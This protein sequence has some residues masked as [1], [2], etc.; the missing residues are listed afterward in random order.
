MSSAK[1][2]IT[3][4]QKAKGL[5]QRLGIAGHPLVQSIQLRNDVRHVVLHCH[6]DMSER[7]Q[8]AADS[9]LVGAAYDA[10]TNTITLA[11]ADELEHA[12]RDFGLHD[13]DFIFPEP[14]IEEVLM[15]SSSRETQHF[16]RG[17]DGHGLNIGFDVR[18]TSGTPQAYIAI[19]GDIEGTLGEMQRALTR[20]T[21]PYEPDPSARR[22]S[23]GL[24]FTGGAGIRIPVPANDQ[25]H[26]VNCIAGVRT[27]DAAQ[28]TRAAEELTDGLAISMDLHRNAKLSA[29]GSS[30]AGAAVSG[31]SMDAAVTGHKL[32]SRIHWR[33]EPNGQ[34]GGIMLVNDRQTSDRTKK[35]D[36]MRQK[37]SAAGIP[38]KPS[39]THAALIL[40]NP[41]DLARALDVLQFDGHT[42]GVVKA[43]YARSQT[44]GAQAGKVGERVREIARHH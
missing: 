20:A 38:Y 4:V 36:E 12:L 30:A 1:Q 40:T 3:N 13:S 17:S 25:E 14:L 8:L 7:A 19:S 42:A 41:Q 43:L 37:L 22:G 18:E 32:V 33:H 34:E 23:S 39:E 11:E 9:L 2:T 35:A 27:P 31:V 6:P 28:Q 26:I 16:Y 15:H 10:D 5:V 44:P 24:D 29:D 21:I